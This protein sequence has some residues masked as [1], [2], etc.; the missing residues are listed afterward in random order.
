ML[1]D[2][3]IIIIISYTCDMIVDTAP[4]YHSKQVIYD[5]K[6][7]FNFD[8][9][10]NILFSTVIIIHE[11]K[12]KFTLLMHSDF[13]TISLQILLCWKG[14]AHC[15]H[16]YCA[17]L[18]K[19]NLDRHLAIKCECTFIVP[20]TLNTE[21]YVHSNVNRKCVQPETIRDLAPCTE[22]EA[23]I[24]PTTINFWRLWYLLKGWQLH[25]FSP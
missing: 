14:L 18:W 2:L 25:A 12:T 3:I 1:Y 4:L 16:N 20:I 13:I 9:T 17:K 15:V 7:Q 11:W 21:V 22:S 10:T 19:T 24:F 5:T 8:S 23:T 6:L